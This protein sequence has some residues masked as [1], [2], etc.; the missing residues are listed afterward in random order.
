MGGWS[1]CLVWRGVLSS[2]ITPRC[3]CFLL[4]AAA[5]NK[6]SNGGPN[7][8]G[9]LRSTALSGASAVKAAAP[10]ALLL[11]HKLP[12]HNRFSVKQDAS[13][14]ANVAKLLCGLIEFSQVGVCKCIRAADMQGSRCRRAFSHA[15]ADGEIAHRH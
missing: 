6:T 13:I 8:S 5:V 12:L 10:S 11:F 2:A 7:F 1:W 4:S 15:T 9:S 14:G 3:V